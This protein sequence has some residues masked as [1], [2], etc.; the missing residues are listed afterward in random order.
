[1]C[2]H[3]FSLLLIDHYCIVSHVSSSPKLRFTHYYEI[4]HLFFGYLSVHLVWN[5][6]EQN[7]DQ[8]LVL[9]LSWFFGYLLTQLATYLG[10]LTY[11]KWCL[12]EAHFR[13]FKVCISHGQ[14]DIIT[15]INFKQWSLVLTLILDHLGLYFQLRS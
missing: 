9:F 2:M 15:K 4:M 11:S 12:S 1:M 10:R 6:I 14:R 3:N 13:A 8:S 5:K 7:I